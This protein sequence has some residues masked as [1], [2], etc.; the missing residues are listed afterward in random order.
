MSRKTFA[1][2]LRKDI[3]VRRTGR[4]VEVTGAGLTYRSNRANAHTAETF[5]S[6]IPVAVIAPPIR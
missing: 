6:K 5:N 2:T 3:H 4:T 1:N